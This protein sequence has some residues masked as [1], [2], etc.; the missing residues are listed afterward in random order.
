[1]SDLRNK[2]VFVPVLRKLQI[3]QIADDKILSSYLRAYK[4][5]FVG[6]GGANA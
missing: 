1:M 5:I 6:E 3:K 4:T 2:N